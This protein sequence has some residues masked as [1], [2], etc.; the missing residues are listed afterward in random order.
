[1]ADH[2]YRDWRS[3]RLV[4]SFLQKPWGK[5]WNETMG[6]QAD[7]QVN[8]AQQAV[9]AAFVDTCPNDALAPLGASSDMDRYPADTDAS[10]RARIAARWDTW[11]M[12]GT[13]DGVKGQ[14]QAFGFP[15]VEI[16]DVRASVPPVSP[17]PP[18]PR[19]AKPSW[20]TSLFPGVAWP[21]A[22]GADSALWWSRFWV[23]LSE[24]F[25]AVLGW[26]PRTWG[27]AN[28]R[29][30]LRYRWGERGPDGSRYTW[31]STATA[32]Q[33]ASLRALITK[34][35][36]VDTICAGIWINFASGPVLRWAGRA[37][38]IGS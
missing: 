21:P 38:G 36:P 28:P 4:P 16:Y 24:P 26:S 17:W 32:S 22:A 12:A 25:P 18:Q 33:V 35:K 9:S 2:A 10:Y 15:S 8:A 6:D 23:V 29:T 3:Q 7:L 14:L 34:W 20:W 27:S 19:C 30:G 11:P 5:R 37:D 13:Y 1:M 31:G